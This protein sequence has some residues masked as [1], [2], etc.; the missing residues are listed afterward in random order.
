MLGFHLGGLKNVFFAGEIKRYG[1]R[2]FS[3]RCTCGKNTLECEFWSKMINSNSEYFSMSSRND[4]ILR[5]A[6]SNFKYILLGP[7]RKS[8]SIEKK[9]MQN[10]YHFTNHTFEK[11]NY[12]VDSSKSLNRLIV[13]KAIPDIEVHTIYLKRNLRDN[14]AS[15]VKREQNMILNLLRLRINDWLIKW[16]L[17]RKSIKHYRMSYEDF[18]SN[19]KSTTKDLCDFFKMDSCE[20]KLNDDLK[21]HVVSGSS[22]TRRSYEDNPRMKITN[23]NI[24]EPFS[25]HQQKILKILGL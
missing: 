4:N 11:C 23:M 16:Y 18:V 14:L 25:K 5:K 1:K 10:L 6:I 2:I 3:R 24:D 8:I 20:E 17:K 9:L 19:Q 22:K 21:Y 15:F 7:S 12:I 13:L